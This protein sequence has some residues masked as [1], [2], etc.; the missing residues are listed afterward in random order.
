MNGLEGI[1][2]ILVNVWF[3]LYGIINNMLQFVSKF[4]QGGG[5][6]ETKKQEP[7]RK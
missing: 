3:R 4:D 5:V 6:Q 1:S 2:D 7:R